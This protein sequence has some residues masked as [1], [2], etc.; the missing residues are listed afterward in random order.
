M[1]SWI[2]F[3]LMLCSWMALEAQN[4]PPDVGT[5]AGTA[6]LAN[7]GAFI[8]IV[9][10]KLGTPAEQTVSFLKANYP[11]LRITFE[12]T[13][14]YNHLFDT[15]G[16]EDPRRKFVHTINAAP[17][18]GEPDSFL[19]GV[20]VPPSKQVVHSISHKLTLKEPVAIM[21]LVAGLRKKYGHETDG[22]ETNVY[23]NGPQ[24][25]TL[26]WVFDSNGNQLPREAVVKETSSCFVG[27]FGGMGV[28]DIKL[29]QG[30]GY[31]DRN[32]AWSRFKDNACM[33]YV[34]LTAVI[35]M[36]NPST[37]MNGV[38]NYLNVTAVNW[39][40]ILSGANAFYAYI[41]QVQRGL[42]DK[43]MRDAQQRGGDI[44]Y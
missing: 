19:I 3:V 6:K 2:S 1:R 40:A 39:P 13:A 9:G 37:S 34:V 16:Q 4:A 41:D 31:D 32:Y 12:R 18:G 29:R 22:P 15:L 10:L 14:D 36:Q 25:K 7:A 23:F 27:E 30:P 38:A 8:D 43:A 28:P 21:N 20:S 33:R 26:V 35:L 5:P 44:K 17:I 24:M 42:S 11:G